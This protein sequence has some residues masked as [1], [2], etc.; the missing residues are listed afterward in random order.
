MKQ[1]RSQK[2]EAMTV[3]LRSGGTVTLEM[4]G[5]CCELSRQDR[6]FVHGLIER[7]DRY[8]DEPAAQPVSHAAEGR[9]SRSRG[10]RGVIRAWVLLSQ[11]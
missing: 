8:Q 2:N 10:S 1:W 11:R 3:A 6:Y 5:D 9:A 7:L 4:T